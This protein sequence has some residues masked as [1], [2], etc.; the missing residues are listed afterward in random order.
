MLR[1]EGFYF[2]DY[3]PTSSRKYILEGK[4]S[5]KRAIKTAVRNLLHI[6][7]YFHNEMRKCVEYPGELA[8]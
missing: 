8:A 5:T 1:C 3:A 6:G 2:H 7:L 4:H